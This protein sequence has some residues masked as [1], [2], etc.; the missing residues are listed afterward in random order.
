MSDE[1]LLIGVNKD[2]QAAEDAVRGSGASGL[3]VPSDLVPVSFFGVLK[4]EFQSDPNSSEP[5]A[6]EYK[7]TVQI[8]RGTPAER[9]GDFVWMNVRQLGALRTTGSA[10]EINYYPLDMFNRFAFKK[11]TVVGVTL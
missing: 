7:Q 8:P 3:S 9:I 2:A 11:S 1:D 6:I 4:K 5:E 10:G